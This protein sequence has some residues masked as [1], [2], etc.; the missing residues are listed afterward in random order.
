MKINYYFI[1]SFHYVILIFSTFIVVHRFYNRKINYQLN[2]YHSLIN[3]LEHNIIK[4]FL[5]ML[6]TIFFKNLV[7][8]FWEQ[9][10]TLRSL[11]R[12]MNLKINF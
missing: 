11:F 8:G 6:E 1:L 12:I 9:N 2:K 3:S 7:F 5:V 10:P 4:Y